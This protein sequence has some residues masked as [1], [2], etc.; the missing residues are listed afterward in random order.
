MHGTVADDI[1][2]VGTRKGDP[3]AALFYGHT[4]SAARRLPGRAGC[5]LLDEAEARATLA[6]VGPLLEQ[7]TG[8]RAAFS[9][10][11]EAWREAMTDAP[12]LKPLDLLDEPLRVLRRA[13]DTG[14][15][16]V[17]VTLRQ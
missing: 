17:A 11:V 6:V 2:M 13:A 14:S 10:R 3:V 8:G 5:F 1:F 9:A 7:P 12:E 15:A 4:F 16:V